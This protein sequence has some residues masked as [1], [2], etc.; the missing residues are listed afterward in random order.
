LQRRLRA[1]AIVRGAIALERRPFVM[2]LRELRLRFGIGTAR[3]V[4]T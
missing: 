1:A 4:V 3:Q 2:K